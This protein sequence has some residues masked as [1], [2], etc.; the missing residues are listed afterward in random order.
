[1]AEARKARILVDLIRQ[2]LD[3][4][5]PEARKAAQGLLDL[6]RRGIL[7]PGI[8]TMERIEPETMKE[9]QALPNQDDDCH[10]AWS[11]GVAR[12]VTQWLVT[13]VA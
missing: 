2:L 13:C 8:Q 12:R 7:K 11:P 10:G 3:N 9:A 5:H 1:M 4:N 6:A